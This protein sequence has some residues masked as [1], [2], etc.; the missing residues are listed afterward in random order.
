MTSARFTRSRIF[1]RYPELGDGVHS[2]VEMVWRDQ[3]LLC[4]YRGADHIPERRGQQDVLPF[5]DGSIDYV[6]GVDVFEHLNPARQLA[7]LTE[8]LRVS[9]K[10]ACLSC[11]FEHPGQFGQ[12]ALKASLLDQLAGIP[13]A[14][15]DDFAID[16]PK[17]SWIMD[18][19]LRLGLAFDFFGDRT[20]LQHYAGLL[21]GQEF[22]FANALLER[23]HWKCPTE[24]ALTG[25]TWD[26]FHSYALCIHKQRELGPAPAALP[27]PR[28][29]RA[30]GDA[31]SVYA[32]CHNPADIEDFGGVKILRVGRAA[33]GAPAGEPGD[34]LSDGSRLLNSRWSEMSGLYRIWMEGPRSE[35]VG[36]CH[37]RRFFN[38]SNPAPAAPVTVIHRRDVPRVRDS[39]LAPGIHERCMAERLI[40]VPHEFGF[41]KSPFHQY[42]DIHTAEDLCLLLSLISKRQPQLLPYARNLFSGTSLFPCNMFIMGWP[43]FDELCPVW[44]G[45]LRE[46][47]S[48]VP[49]GRATAYQNRD[50]SFLAERLFDVLLRH[51]VDKLGV[52][53]EQQPTYFVER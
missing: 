15:A 38:F 43:L 4:R 27:P 8:M 7:L 29:E 33:D 10:A 44:F 18:H 34:I 48:L 6:L 32:C 30:S 35:V 17:L 39:F 36:F 45:L 19:V 47:E 20:M 51:A 12:A 21:L 28:G 1:A 50:L 5:P 46:F 37:Y 14:F 11:A 24:P 41:G 3:R 40:I 2:V 31:L 25:S 9:R 42:A 53:L 16:L 22:S 13:R 23:Q 26:I 49:A 52:R